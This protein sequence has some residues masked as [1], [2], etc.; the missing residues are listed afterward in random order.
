MFWVACVSACDLKVTQSYVRTSSMVG[1]QTRRRSAVVGW[2]SEIA[3]LTF[4]V[5]LEISAFI[6]LQLKACKI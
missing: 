2:S 4:N 3:E 6:L 5:Y 1:G